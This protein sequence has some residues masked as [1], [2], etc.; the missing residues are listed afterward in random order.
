MEA[1]PSRAACMHACMRMVVLLVLIGEGIGCAQASY[2]AAEVP[3]LLHV[4]VLASSRPVQPHACMLMNALCQPQRGTARRARTHD[5]GGMP[6]Q[7]SGQAWPNLAPPAVELDD[8]FFLFQCLSS[9]AVRVLLVARVL[10]SHRMQQDPC[11]CRQLRSNIVCSAR[12]RRR[13]CRQLASQP[14]FAN[15]SPHRSWATSCSHRPFNEQQAARAGDF[16]RLQ[17]S[18]GGKPVA[19]SPAATQHAHQATLQLRRSHAGGRCRG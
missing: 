8:D 7:C 18:Q 3:L 17:T 14:A 19:S 12:R 5:Q 16:R 13:R 2:A 15:V 11:S 9:M 10:P 4:S 6:G 1:S